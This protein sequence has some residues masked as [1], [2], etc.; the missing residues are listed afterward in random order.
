HEAPAEADP[1]TARRRRRA[2]RRKKGEERARDEG[3]GQGDGHSTPEGVERGAGRLH[4]LDDGR[5]DVRFVGRPRTAGD[6]SVERGDRGVDGGAAVDGGGGEEAAVD[7]AGAGVQRAT[8]EAGG[9]AGVRCAAA[10]DYE[11][12]RVRG[13][14]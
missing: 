8:G 11:A 5:E 7:S 1:R 13:G 6:V 14:M 4:G 10:E 3:A 12:V 9:D 2:G